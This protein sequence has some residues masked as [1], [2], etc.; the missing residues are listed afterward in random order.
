VPSGTAALEIYRATQVAIDA[1]TQDLAALGFNRAV[2]RAYE[3]TNAL[4]GFVPKTQE[5]TDTYLYALAK[6]AQL[7]GP[8]MPHLG[9]S[10]W[11][12]V[13][14]QGLLAQAAWPKADMSVLASDEILMPVQINGKR[15]AEIK[16]PKDADN[17]MIE[18]LVLAE[19]QVEKFVD[20]KPIKKTIIV[21]GRIINLVL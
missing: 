10:G 8:M 20:G 17:A 14:G 15:R 11:R 13:G 21:P 3:L 16:V 2:A 18:A 19:P 5:D 6:L 12:I 1:I 4:S 9:E 7:I